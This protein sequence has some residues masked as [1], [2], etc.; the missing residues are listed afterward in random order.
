MSIIVGL[1]GFSKAGKDECGKTFIK[2]G[3]NRYAFGDEVKHEYAK[4]NN[5][6]DEDMFNHNKD[7]NRP[8]IIAHGEGMRKNN[9]NY[10]INVVKDNILKDVDNNDNV[11]ITDMRRI[12]EI[13]FLIELQNQY[14]KNKVFLIEIERPK[15]NGGEYDEDGETSKA[16]TYAR[17]HGYVDIHIL[18]QT[19]DE[20][21]ADL[22]DDIITQVLIEKDGNNN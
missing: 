10:W 8:G 1:L 12:P 15:N 5:L 4:L 21:L 20:A 22:V 18:N 2:H 3:F 19:T 16:I 17:F 14:G 11:V 13:D 7:K 6:L 9:P